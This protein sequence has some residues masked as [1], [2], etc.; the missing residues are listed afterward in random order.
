M[1]EQ[2]SRIVILKTLLCASALVALAATTGRAGTIEVCDAQVSLV[3]ARDG[4]SVTI[5]VQIHS[6]EDVSGWISARFSS[7]SGA[8]YDDPE[9]ENARQTEVI[10]RGTF[11]CERCFDLNVAAVA[12]RGLQEPE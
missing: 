4:E 11:W 10:R 5:R 6:A 8:W 1:V 12:Q 3:V 9:R 7:A 2:G